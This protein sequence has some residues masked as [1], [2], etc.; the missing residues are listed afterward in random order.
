MYSATM[1]PKSGC[2]VTGQS[3]VYSGK[4]RLMM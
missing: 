4:A 1:T 2:P 3:E